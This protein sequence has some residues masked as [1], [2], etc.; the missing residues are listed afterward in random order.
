MISAN[1]ARVIHRELLLLGVS[2]QALL[3]GTGLDRNR[4][5]HAAQLDPEQFLALLQNAR[6]L[7]NDAPLGFM[8]AGRNRLAG[9]GMMGM[10]MVSAPTLRDGLQA[11]V[12]FSSLQ[13]GYLQLRVT[14]GQPH[15][16]IQL[17]TNRD[18]GDCHDIHV[19]SV[20]SLI[21]EYME[22]VTG[23][24]ETAGGAKVTFRLSYP[25]AGRR[26]LYEHYL[27]GDVL[28]EQHTN[29]VEFPSR[30]L[31]RPSPYADAELW[32]LARRYLSE[33]LQ[34]S[35]GENPRP[36]TSHLK[37]MFAAT[38]PPF[39]DIAQVA[40]SLH[41][42]QRTLNRRLRDEG[43]TFRYIRQEA[44]H[45]WARRQLLDGAGVEAIAFELGYDNP[46]NFRRSFRE[47]LGLSPTEW[48]RSQRDQDPPF[49]QAAP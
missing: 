6:A 21:Q 14:A 39:P 9:L 26:G 49:N 4:I 28:F 1:F 31:E 47:F 23:H 12:S 33:R 34:K 44:T 19:E 27:H 13:A 22:D 7:I 18:L 17:T 36:F 16:R 10:A 48:L 43:S 11:M 20:F 35:A 25:E 45:N 38:Q 37:S 46:A 3:L 30:W 32:M 41:L 29:E 42:S 8:V 15:T 40:D 24:F 5:W 2:E